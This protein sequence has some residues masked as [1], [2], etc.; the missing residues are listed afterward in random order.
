MNLDFK[1]NLSLRTENAVTKKVLK[2][3]F[4]CTITSKLNTISSKVNTIPSKLN[5]VELDF[6][7]RRDKN[8][9]GFKNQISS[10]RSFANFKGIMD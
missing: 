10:D 8:Q 7:K 4:D 2:V 6:K 5:T 3:K 1:N 9:L